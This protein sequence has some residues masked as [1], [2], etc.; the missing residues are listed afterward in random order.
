V[1]LKT[2]YRKTDKII[3]YI[4][5]RL[6]E[7]FGKLK[8]VMTFDRLNIMQAV[9]DTYAEAD[10]I[11]REAYLALAQHVYTD[12]VKNDVGRKIDEDWLDFVLSA[13]D[14]VSKYVYANEFDRKRSRLAEA[15]IASTTKTA[16]VDTA[17]R[18]LSFMARIYAVI[19][20]DKAY[21]QAMTDNNVKKV[22]WVAEKDEKTCSVCHKR[23]GK[24][25][26]LK[27]LPPKPHPNCR[28]WYKEV[29][30]RH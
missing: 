25:Y 8:S 28:C 9:K 19:V 6:I 22:V 21:L 13:Y 15:L 2:M 1:R 5:N 4:N 27:E 12:K 20:T 17:L 16:E 11:I 10:E 7:I 26:L 3:E 14:P 30:N 29:R 24:V 18:A 23:D